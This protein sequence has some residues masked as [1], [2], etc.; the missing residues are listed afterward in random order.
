MDEVMIDE[1][2]MD[3][4]D[5]AESLEEIQEQMLQLLHRAE[6]VLRDPRIPHLRRRAE[7]YWVGHINTALGSKSYPTNSPTMQSTIDELWEESGGAP[8]DM[9]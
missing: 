8:D 4:S 6:L 7:S 3:V 1:E 9:F 2:M 5:L